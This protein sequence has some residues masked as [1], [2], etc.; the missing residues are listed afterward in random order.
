[1]L[2]VNYKNGFYRYFFAADDPGLSRAY[3][4]KQKPMIPGKKP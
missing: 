1:M 4:C 2:F 3:E